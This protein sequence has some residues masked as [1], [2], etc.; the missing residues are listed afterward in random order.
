MRKFLKRIAR[1]FGYE[2]H[3]IPQGKSEIWIDVGAHTGQLTLEYA[4]WHPNVLIFAFEP[5]IRVLGSLIGKLK[6]FIV[7]PMAVS[8]TDGVAEF[9]INA[10]DGTS[11]LLPFNPEAFGQDWKESDGLFTKMREIVPTIRLDT[12]LSRMGI[13]IVDYLKIDTQGADLM[14]V[15]SLGDRLKDVR[16]LTLEADVTP[17]RAYKGSSPKDEI[18]D[19]LIS[20]NFELVR[21]RPQ[22]GG[23]EEDLTFVRREE[24]HTQIHF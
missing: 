20:H 16:S 3:K 11:S 21:T 1:H 15:R 5:D 6:N 23:K 9:F 8:E 7:M 18:V 12:F 24:G 17:I 22:T 4:E 19:F 14:V 13:D 10:A 2:L